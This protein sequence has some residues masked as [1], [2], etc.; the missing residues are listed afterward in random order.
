MNLLKFLNEAT[1][2]G[3]VELGPNVLFD[4][5]RGEFY[6][7]SWI[8]G[9]MFAASIDALLEKMTKRAE[10]RR[11]KPQKKIFILDKVRDEEGKFKKQ[12]TTR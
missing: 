11:Y 3:E 4:R 6:G 5:K 1:K 10:S 2:H 7:F 12:E 8:T 9:P